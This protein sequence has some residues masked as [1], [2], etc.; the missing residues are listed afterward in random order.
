MPADADPEPARRRDIRVVQPECHNGG[1]PTRRQPDHQGAIT[2]PGKVFKP[3]LGARIEE[4]NALAAVGVHSVDL[5]PLEL[6]AA[7]AGKPEILDGGGATQ[8][9]RKD[10]LD[11]QR[12]A[13]DERRGPT[14]TAAAPSILQQSPVQ[15]LVGR[16]RHDSPSSSASVGMRSPRHLRS[17][18]AYALRNSSLSASLRRRISSWRPS[19]SSVPVCRA[20]AR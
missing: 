7:P 19:S 3:G 11:R 4:R 6:I 5:R 8:R 12:L 18:A 1:A 15:P 2:R 9:P 16:R 17:K 13:N 20:H 14:V 10:V